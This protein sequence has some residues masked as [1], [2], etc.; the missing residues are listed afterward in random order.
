[1]QSLLIIFFKCDAMHIVS[2]MLKVKWQLHTEE[3]E[4]KKKLLLGS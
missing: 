4:G 1:M 2:E 3:T